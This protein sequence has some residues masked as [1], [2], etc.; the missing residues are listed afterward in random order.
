MPLDTEFVSALRQ[1]LEQ[2]QPLTIRELI[3]WAGERT[4]DLWLAVATQQVFVDIDKDLLSSG[5]SLV[6]TDPDTATRL[7]A[8]AATSSRPRAA[9][10][11]ELSTGARLAWDGTPLT[12]LNSTDSAVVLDPDVG[13]VVEVPTELAMTLFE[14]GRLVSLDDSISAAQ[15]SA[16]DLWMRISKGDRLVAVERKRALES[17]DGSV[18]TRS[19]ARWEKAIRN[20][21]R[22]YGF[23][24]LG[25]VPKK[26]SGNTNG[27]LT[28]DEEEAITEA[29]EK[30][31]LKPNG[32]SAKIAHRLYKRQAKKDHR[33]PASYGAFLKRLSRIPQEVVVDRRKGR[34]AAYSL[35]RR[36]T[37]GADSLPLSQHPWDLMAMDAT[38][39]DIE[40][41]DSESGDSLGRPWLLHGLDPTFGFNFSFDVSFDPPSAASDLRL[42]RE[43]VR[44]HNRLTDRA[45][46]DGARE[47]KSTDVEWFSAAYEMFIETNPPWLSRFNAAKESSFGSM[48]RN[49]IHNLAG[50]TQATKRVRELTDEVR[51]SKHACWT[52]AELHDLLADYFYNV[53]NNSPHPTLH[54][55]PAELYQRYGR[56]FGQQTRRFIPYDEGFVLNTLPSTR[57]GTSKNQPGRGLKV[58][59]AYY[60][61][62]ELAL[63]PNGESY[64]VRWDPDDLGAVWAYVDGL[65]IKCVSP[66]PYRQGFSMGELRIVTR[67]L[68]LRKLLSRQRLEEEDLLAALLEAVDGKEVALKEFRKQRLRAAEHRR[69]RARLELPTPSVPNAISAV[70]W[71]LEGLSPHEA[72]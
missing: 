50:N 18:S 34:K 4:P 30:H 51:P 39:M 49:L 17:S 59:G 45:L 46:L 22:V 35:T 64:E 10:I 31:Y 11:L 72:A 62:D 6:Y 63:R 7:D 61:C 53:R 14:E 52:L 60:N 20:A 43:T 38:R 5:K 12:V 29:L 8:T 9:H 1:H 71:T 56:R 68:R 2:L 23:G 13:K 15:R 55:T 48:D 24:I 40:L 44:R 65:W 70:D 27:R 69:L 66:A 54:A 3:E 19:R 37:R 21:E 41:V 47:H 36:Y 33:A 32:P 67:E 25:L 28:V 58:H 26:R 16:Q 57:K 42:C